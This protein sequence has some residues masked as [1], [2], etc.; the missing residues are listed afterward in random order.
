M[1]GSFPLLP[2]HSLAQ[3][4]GHWGEKLM[5]SF[6]PKKIDEQ[7]LKELSK[8]TPQEYFQFVSNAGRLEHV[9]FIQAHKSTPKVESQLQFPLR[10]FYDVGFDIY[11]VRLDHENF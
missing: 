8:M 2:S 7:G 4:C 5:E 11:G 1:V 10:Q 9:K 3:G 6:F